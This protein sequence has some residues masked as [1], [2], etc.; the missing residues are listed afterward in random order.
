M[1]TKLDDTSPENQDTTALPRNRGPGR[2]VIIMIVVFA[3]STTVHFLLNTFLSVEMTTPVPRYK[4]HRN[5]TVRVSQPAVTSRNP[6]LAPVSVSPHPTWTF[7]DKA[8]QE[9]RKSA[10]RLHPDIFLNRSTM[11]NWKEKPSLTC[12]VTAKTR[13]NQTCHS[14][15]NIGHYRTCAVVGNGGI[16]LRSQCGPFI[17]SKDYVIRIDL[18]AV[19]GFERDVGRRTNMT[20]LNMSTPKRVEESLQMK[21]RSQDVYESRLQNINGTVIVADRLSVGKLTRAFRKYR[22]SFVLL[23]SSERLK[24]GSGIRNVMSGVTGKRALGSPSTGLLTV[25]MASTF[26]DQLYLYGFFPFQRDEKKRPVPYHYYPD[27][28]VKPILQA[29]KHHMSNEYNMYRQLQKRGVLKL[30]V[31]K[32]VK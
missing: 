32:C 23:F 16:L 7:N 4:L 31:G 20:V 11:V 18:P 10:A 26:C 2:R 28:Y 19:K 29:G 12:N 5:V 8:L 6:V 3:V 30:H 15:H 13:N 17:D 24:R 21:N 14:Q 1:A 27:D 25:L 22:Q 9:I